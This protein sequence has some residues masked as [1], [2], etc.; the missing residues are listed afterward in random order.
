MIKGEPQGWWRF[1]LGEG[2]A[3]N[4]GSS[5]LPRIFVAIGVLSQGGMLSP[6]WLAKDVAGAKPPM[7]LLKKIRLGI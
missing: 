6:R 2:I 7:N 5:P 3:L 4:P 1:E